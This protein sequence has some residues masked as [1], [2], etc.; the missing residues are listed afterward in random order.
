M[1]N[2]FARRIAKLEQQILADMKQTMQS[3]PI[4]ISAFV[5]T[6]MRS[7]SDKKGLVRSQRTGNFYYN[8]PNTESR[9]RT[10]YGNLRRSII[11]GQKGNYKSVEYRNGH[12][13]I[14]FGYAPDTVV[15]AGTRN[16]TLEY[17]PINEKTR[18]FLEPGFAKYFADPEGWKALRQ[19]LEDSIFMRINQVFNA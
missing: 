18:P 3:A 7:P 2:D 9:L 15:R 11:V 19:E 10:L 1:S 12:F 6:F 14:E 13:Y 17:G 16:T 8:E 5:Q 4:E